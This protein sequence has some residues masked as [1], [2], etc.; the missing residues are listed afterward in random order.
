MRCLVLSL[1]QKLITTHSHE[2]LPSNEIKIAKCPRSWAFDPNSWF[3]DFWSEIKMTAINSWH[4]C[5]RRS[6]LSPPISPKLLPDCCKVMEQKKEKGNC[7]DEKNGS[8][9]SAP[10]IW[11]RPEVDSGRLIYCWSSKCFKSGY[12]SISLISRSIGSLWYLYW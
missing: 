11:G 3:P 9:G 1:Q 5:W 6:L 10:R 7:R 8:W 4:Q 2:S 12:I